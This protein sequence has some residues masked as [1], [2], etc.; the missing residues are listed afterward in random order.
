[1]KKISI[2]IPVYN[3]EKYIERAILSALNQNFKDE[4][5]E[6]I[7][8]NDESPDNSVEI[9]ENLMKQHAQIKLFSQQ[10]KGLGGARNT[11]IQ[12]AQGSYILFLDADDYL[13]KETLPKIIDHSINNNLDILE[14]GAVGVT[15]LKKEIYRKSITTDEVLDG[16]SYLNYY[17]YMN[18][19]CNKLYALD[20][21][22]KNKL[23]FKEQIFIEDFEF[24]TRA[25][26]F[27][28][29]V[30]G[31]KTIVANFIQTTDSITRNK[32]V[33][34]NEKM[35]FDIKEVIELIL[36]FSKTIDRNNKMVGA[37]VNERVSF[38]IVT[39]L[40]TIFKFNISS[41]IRTAIIKELKKEN[42]Y[43]IKT[44]IKDK[45]KNIFRR[46]VNNEFI[47]NTSCDIKSFITNK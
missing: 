5:F 45:K 34:K 23:Y 26:Y 20:F 22:K 41:K 29:R 14:F 44:I 30:R 40:F 25:F 37:V 24:N 46:L 10:N 16:Y 38:L 47:F 11:G 39:L 31:I 42:L 2:I 1:M 32:N 21:L 7:V 43:P 36:S 18:S 8:V 19:A 13:E 17:Q 35:V 15:E 3:V 28:K 9:V 6:I 33:V 12:N 4:E 27:A